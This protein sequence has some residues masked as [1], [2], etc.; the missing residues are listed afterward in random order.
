MQLKNF[1]VGCLMFIS[2]SYAQAQLLPS[3]VT[4]AL[5]TV[6]QA[7]DAVQ[8]A[9]DTVQEASDKVEKTVDTAKDAT[10]AEKDD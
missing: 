9:V 5:E 8:E 3:I 4:D 6:Q 10:S 7:A 2:A 1:T